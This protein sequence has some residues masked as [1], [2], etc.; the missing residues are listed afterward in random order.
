[1]AEQ[2][3]VDR[4]GTPQIDHLYAVFD[5]EDQANEAEK[6]LSSQGV[7]TERLHTQQH[8]RALQEP[9]SKI[10]KVMRA[11]TKGFGGEGNEAER[12]ARHVQEGRIVLTVAAP[13]KDAADA[14]TQTLTQHGAYDVTYF[15]P[16]GIE[17]MSASE[18]QEHGLPTHS[19]GNT[20]E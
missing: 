7:T 20:I 3:S 16:L 6:A 8:A 10:G 2:E 5:R 11:V 18:N 13:N 17:Y 9:E 12:Y 4:A 15:R 14:V 1:M 19:A